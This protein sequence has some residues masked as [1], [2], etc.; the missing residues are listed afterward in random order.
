MPEKKK[1]TNASTRRDFLKASTVAT[2]AALYGSLKIAPGVFAAGSE[3][4]RVWS[5]CATFLWTAS[6]GNVM[7]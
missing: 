6:K 3:T 1:E 4:V 7:H 2:S 5:R